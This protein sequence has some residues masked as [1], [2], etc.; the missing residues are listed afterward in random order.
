MYYN[1]NHGVF[2]IPNDVHEVFNAGG[3]VELINSRINVALF[4][5]I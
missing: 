4:G 2:F 1:L 3:K 5:L